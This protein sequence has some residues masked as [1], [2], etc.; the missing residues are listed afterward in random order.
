MS[1]LP[2]IL[3]AQLEKNRTKSIGLSLMPT[4]QTTVAK[5]IAQLQRVIYLNPE[6]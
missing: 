3:P 5:C 6:D 4:L 1:D 2:L